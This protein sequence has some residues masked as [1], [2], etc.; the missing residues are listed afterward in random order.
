MIVNNNGAITMG[1]WYA[2]FNGRI[3]DQYSA[4]ELYR[5]KNGN[6]I[7]LP[8]YNSMIM[9]IDVGSF[10]FPDKPNSSQFIKRDLWGRWCMG[11]NFV[12]SFPSISTQSVNNYGYFSDY[13]FI[14]SGVNNLTY[15][16]GQGIEPPFTISITAL[17]QNDYDYRAFFSLSN[18][19]RF[20][21]VGQVIEI[22]SNYST[23]SNRVSNCAIDDYNHYH[24]YTFIAN[25]KDGGGIRFTV[26]RDGESP[27]SSLDIS[28][29][30]YITS[31]IHFNR[32]TESQYFGIGNCQFKSVRC[33][34]SALT[35]S[36]ALDIAKW[37]G[38][39]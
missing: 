6:I 12:D 8:K 7:K 31:V 32:K 10:C 39:I 35:Q 27:Y 18:G 13:F 28:S 21:K 11:V 30:S 26:Y 36:D 22:Y 9:N 14:G 25:R 20:E 23:P 1:D 16:F 37:D 19:V 29:N 5:N 24:N 2:N 34:K 15:N 38:I 3:V 17:T 4:V 33:W